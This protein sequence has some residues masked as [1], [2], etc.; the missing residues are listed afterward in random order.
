MRGT[1]AKSL[2]EILAAVRAAGIS[3]GDLPDQLFGVVETLDSA[4]ALR[5]VLTDPSTSAEGKMAL[6]TSVFAPKIGSAALSILT[7]AVAGRWAAGRDL[8]DAVELAGVA[9]VIAAADSTG[10]LDDLENQLF[11]AGEVI[12]DDVELRRVISDRAVPAAGKASLL[13]NVFGDKIGPAALKILT[14]ASASR[15]GSFERVLPAFGRLVAEARG[16]L[17]ATVRAAYELSADE[18]TRLAAALGSKYGKDVQVNL[19][20]DPSVVGGVEVSVGAEVVDATMSTRL[21]AAR[22]QLAG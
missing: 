4:P 17:V 12:H 11:A 10:G 9:A 3:D 15:T 7:T 1:S 2:D 18:R 22:R 14:Q 16:R 13:K 21:E 6:A 19:I 8:A 20:V 5:R